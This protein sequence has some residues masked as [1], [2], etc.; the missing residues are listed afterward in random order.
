[1]KA[2]NYF[3]VS[4]SKS[5]DSVSLCAYMETGEKYLLYS[6]ITAHVFILV[7]AAVAV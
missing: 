6:T 7:A 2:T 1:M 4:V 3:V 5:R